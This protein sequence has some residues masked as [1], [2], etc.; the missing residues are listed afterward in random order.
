MRESLDRY[1]LDFDI[2]VQDA[3]WRIIDPVEFRQAVLPLADPVERL[4][5]AAE[6]GFA[7]LACTDTNGVYG[8]VEFQRACEAAGE[9]PGPTRSGRPPSGR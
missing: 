9:D 7:A 6:R 8:A 3:R 4:A 5:A 2:P 1:A